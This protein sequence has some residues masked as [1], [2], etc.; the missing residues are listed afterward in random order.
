MC[1]SSENTCSREK[2][3]PFDKVLFRCEP[4]LVGAYTNSNFLCY[5]SFTG[6]GQLLWVRVACGTVF[7]EPFNL[8]SMVSINLGI[9]FY[10]V[11]TAT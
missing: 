8:V 2:A 5:N 10:G 4:G 3:I 1:G 6:R 9:R 11:E 7:G